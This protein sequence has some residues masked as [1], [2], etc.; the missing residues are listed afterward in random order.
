MYARDP[1]FLLDAQE[2]PH[3]VVTDSWDTLSRSKARDYPPEIAH[4]CR[5]PFIVNG[6]LIY[7]LRLNDILSIFADI[8]Y[9]R[10]QPIALI[11]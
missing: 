9:N 6:W 1:M 11:T 8:H 4:T 7:A 10:K 3:A 5:D 2:I